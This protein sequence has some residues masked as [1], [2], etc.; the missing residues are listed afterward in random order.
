MVQ[1]RLPLGL[2]TLLISGRFRI[3]GDESRFRRLKQLGAVSSAGMTSRGALRSLASARGVD[4]L[5]RRGR[6]LWGDFVTR[7]A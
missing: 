3:G 1:L 7:A 5:V 2:T 6:N 4:L